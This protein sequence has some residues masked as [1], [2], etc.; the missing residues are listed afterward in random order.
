MIN[1]IVAIAKGNV[2][3]KDNDLPWHYKEDLQYFKRITLNKIVLMGKNTFMSIINRNKKPLPHRINVV[4]TWEEDFQYEGVKVIND[5]DR[6]LEENKEEDIFIIGGKSIYA[7]LLDRADRLYITHINKEYDGNVL[8]PA[9]DY[10]QFDLL[11]KNDVNELSFC[12]Y[13]RKA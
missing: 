6:F 12:V 7:Y 4:A 8:F 13:Q 5:I 3:G 2:I 9:I 10:T 11:S 1:I